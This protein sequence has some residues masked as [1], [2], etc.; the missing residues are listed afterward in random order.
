MINSSGMWVAGMWDAG[1]VVTQKEGGQGGM[2]GEKIS[3]L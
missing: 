2:V 3:I 1:I